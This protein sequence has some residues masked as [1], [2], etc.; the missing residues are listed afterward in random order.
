M[1]NF[2]L[3]LSQISLERFFQLTRSKR[4]LPGR[5]MLHEMME[6]RFAILARAGITDL[7]VLK[8]QLGSKLKMESFSARW[9]LPYPYLVLLKRE[10]GSYQA[11]PF[12]LSDFP[13]VPFEFTESLRS[14]GLRNTQDFF[15]LAQTGPKRSDLASKTGIPEARLLELFALCDLS[16]ITGVGGTMARFCYEAGIRS[17]REFA[18]VQ[19][20]QLSKFPEEDIRYC[21]EYARVLVEYEL[22]SKPS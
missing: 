13:G 15:E 7:K 18:S 3:D 19:S 21:I 17:V 2:S 14:K 9:D 22:K 12:P 4:M 5:V 1:V 20:P 11:M 16:R 6:D 10:A 8:K